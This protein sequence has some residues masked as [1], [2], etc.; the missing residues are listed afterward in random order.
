MWIKKASFNTGRQ[1]ASRCASEFEE[2]CTLHAG[3]KACKGGIHPNFETYQKSKTKAP[4]TPQKDLCPPV[5]FNKKTKQKTRITELLKRSNGLLTDFT[6]E[7]EGVD[8][9]S[10]FSVRESLSVSVPGR[11]Q[12]VQKIQVS[13]LH[14]S[15][16]SLCIT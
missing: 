14:L 1:E 3:E 6:F 7:E 8:F 9:L 11:Q 4:L 15:S 16:P 5:V 12:N 2:Y 10:D 13:L